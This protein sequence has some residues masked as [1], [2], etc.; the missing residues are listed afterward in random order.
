[1]EEKFGVSSDDLEPVVVEQ[2][3]EEVV[4]EEP[5]NTTEEEPVVEEEEDDSPSLALV[6]SA[7]TIGLIAVARRKH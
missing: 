7:L 1:M 2:A 3:V 4:V 5:T 6:V